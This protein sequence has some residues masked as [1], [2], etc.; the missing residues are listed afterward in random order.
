MA[1]EARITTILVLCLLVAGGGCALVPKPKVVD[2]PAIS[3]EQADWW[4]AN[5][6]QATYVPGRGYYVP[7]VSGFFDDK[8]RKLSTD[9]LH[10]ATAAEDADQEGFLDR[11]APKKAWKRF[12][13]MIGRGP[14]EK[15][16]RT[17]LE[18]GDSLFR[19][20]KFKEAAAKY[21]IAYKRWPDSPLEEE[22]LFKAAECEFFADR[23]V[24][25]DD[26][27]ALLV[28]KFPSTQY[29][30]QVTVRRFAIGRYWDQFDVA[31]HHWPITPNFTDKTRPVF[32]TGGHALHVFER[33]RLDDPTGPLADDSIMAG[34]TSYFLKGRWDDADYHFGLLR[35]EYPKSEFQFQAHLLGLRCKL[36][37][38]Q[39]PGYE[40]TPLDEAEELATQLLTQFPQELANER[41]RVVQVRA[42]IRDQRAL[43]EWDMAEYYAKG[44]YYGASRMYYEKIAKE[45]PETRLAQESRTRLDQYKGLPD[46][47]TPPLQWLVNVLPASKREGPVVPKEVAAMAANPQAPN[48]TVTK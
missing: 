13:A 1:A 20:K 10:G 37:K 41:E 40:G 46:S 17:A 36:L 45:Y 6:H 18:E 21:R 19:Q 9:L 31:H 12:E 7:G 23:Y 3:Q 24:K 33:I 8:G 5:R 38:Y 32:D 15:I 29:V 28:K 30:S 39:G 11:I 42:G 44:K 2:A 27:Y 43:R 48:A 14:N 35:T 16:A 4:E 34:A 25:A 22:A 47:P 26:E